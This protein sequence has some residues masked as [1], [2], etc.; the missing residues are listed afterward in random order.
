MGFCKECG[1]QVDD[2]K[3]V[4]GECTVSITGLD[5]SPFLV[6]SHGS[7]NVLFVG[8]KIYKTNATKKD[9]RIELLEGGMYCGSFRVWKRN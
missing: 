7:S 6:V 1:Q 8:G 2:W 9:Y 3:D 5:G 4:T